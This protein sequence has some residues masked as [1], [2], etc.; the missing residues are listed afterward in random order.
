MLSRP[1]GLHCW[2]EDPA[3]SQV[4]WLRRLCVR[5]GGDIGTVMV[6]CLCSFLCDV[7]SWRDPLPGGGMR[8]IAR[9]RA[10]PRTWEKGTNAASNAREPC[11]P[12]L[13]RLRA[14]SGPQPFGPNMSPSA[15]SPGRLRA[16]N[17]AGMAPKRKLKR[18]VSKEVLPVAVKAVKCIR[19]GVCKRWQVVDLVTVMGHECVSVGST[20][21]WLH[22]LLA[23]QLHQ[24]PFH[25]ATNNFV[26]ECAE[27]ARTQQGVPHEPAASSQGTS[28]PCNGPVA[29]SSGAA[30]SDGAL[31]GKGAVFSEESESDVERPAKIRK[32]RQ[33]T[34]SRARGLSQI[35]VRG[36]QVLC[37]CGPGRRVL[38]PVGDD[39]VHR[40]VQH[41]IP[42]SG[43]P[44]REEVSPF[45]QLLRDSDGR[46]IS[47]RAPPASSHDAVPA[48]HRG[49]WKIAYTNETGQTVQS[50][51]G[52]AVPT[53]DLAGNPL[54]QQELVQAALR[55]LTKAR[56]MWN[57]MDKSAAPRLAE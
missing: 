11:L 54:G 9:R 48:Q 36:M 28:A 8:T 15:V 20:Q 53:M 33:H 49:S 50:Q 2:I 14:V 38:V 21:R 32:P 55:V 26:T 18:Q 52:L 34:A 7:Q 44:A 46:Y 25:G 39:S 12:S 30:P 4:V 19:G 56:R 24:S 57:T 35:V 47:W 40:I 16:N 13:G 10:G 27:A 5:H 41:L 3:L 6:L 31:K 22:T 29:S 23:G 37:A 43:E 1:I 51:C 42:R 17:P 45:T